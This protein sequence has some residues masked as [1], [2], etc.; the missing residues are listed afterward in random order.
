MIASRNTLNKLLQQYQEKLQKHPNSICRQN[1]LQH[2][3]R[4]SAPL[5]ETL[6]S[7]TSSSWLDNHGQLKAA[8]K[9]RQA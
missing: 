1:W 4:L 8:K 3:Q 6:C 7:P 5:K 2:I 9:R